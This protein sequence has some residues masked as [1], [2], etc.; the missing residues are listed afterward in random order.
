MKHKALFEELLHAPQMFSKTPHKFWSKFSFPTHYK[1]HGSEDKWDK[2]KWDNV[3]DWNHDL[4]VKMNQN[5]KDKDLMKEFLPML[6]EYSKN[7]QQAQKFT[8]TGFHGQL[9]DVEFNEV[10]ADL[11]PFLP[12]GLTLLEYEVGHSLIYLLIKEWETDDKEDL[13]DQSRFSLVAAS[14]NQADKY[15]SLI[16]I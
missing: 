9:S 3:E 1:A 15:L 7:L 6:I 8:V 14:Y 2:N 16:H 11:K 4:N 12:Y 13:E 5:V 10:M